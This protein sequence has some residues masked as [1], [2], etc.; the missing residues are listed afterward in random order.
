MPT[1]SITYDA[2]KAYPH[3]ISCTCGE[4]FRGYMSRHAALNIA[5]HHRNTVHHGHGDVTYPDDRTPSGVAYYTPT[6][7]PTIAR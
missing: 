2:H 3:R 1:T 6:N 5:D 4:T 7:H